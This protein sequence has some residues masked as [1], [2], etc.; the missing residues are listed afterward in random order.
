MEEAGSGATE[1]VCCQRHK[2]CG[3]A[4]L[5]K[6]VGRQFWQFVF[7]IPIAHTESYECEFPFQIHREL[8]VP[9]KPL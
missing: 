1:R 4:A 8:S 5:G 2:L 9:R 3:H 6:P 7:K